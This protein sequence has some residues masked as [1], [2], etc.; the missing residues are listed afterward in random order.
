[1]SL[2]GSQCETWDLQREETT[3]SGSI[4]HKEAGMKVQL[5]LNFNVKRAIGPFN[6]VYRR[7]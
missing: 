2:V 5:T 3:S 7:N 1:M 4:Q 6:Q